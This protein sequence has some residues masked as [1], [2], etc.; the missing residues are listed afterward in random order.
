MGLL[1]IRDIALTRLVSMTNT[2]IYGGMAIDLIVGLSGIASRVKTA[3]Q[4]RE[5]RGAIQMEAIRSKNLAATEGSALAYL[6]NKVAHSLFP[7]EPTGSLLCRP[8]EGGSG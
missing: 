5:L 4:R 6:G 3:L 2:F 8:A 1:P 7:N